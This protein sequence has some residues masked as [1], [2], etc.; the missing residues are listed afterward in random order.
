MLGWWFWFRVEDLEFRRT[1]H[2][3]AAERQVA[4]WTWRRQCRS[5]IP[6]A[7]AA[8]AAA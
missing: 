8:A 5:L 1:L 7:L 2:V 4:S 3:G 6:A